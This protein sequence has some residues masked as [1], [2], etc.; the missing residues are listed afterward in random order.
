[1]IRDLGWPGII[2]LGLVQT[3]LGAVVVLTTS[4]LNRIMVVEI[5][6]AA[7]IPGAL[8]A[9]HYAVQL[10]RPRW[11]FGSDAGGRRTPWILGGMAVLA[12]GGFLAA[13]AT[14]L[15]ADRFVPA[16][17]L[18]VLAFLMIGIGVGASGTSL[19][20][21]LAARVAEHRRAA[22]ATTVWVMMIAGF[23][24]TTAVVGSLIDPYSPERLLAASAGV[25]LF[26]VV[27]TALALFRMEPKAATVVPENRAK[28]DF[29]AA[30]AEV[31]AEPQ[32]RRF[33]IFVFVSMLA[34]NG[35]D[36]ILEPFAGLVFGLT[37]GETTKLAGVQH[38]GVLAGMVTMSAVATFFGRAAKRVLTGWMIGG[39]IASA[40]LLATLAATAFAGDVRWLR[41]VV[42]LLGAANGAFAAAAIASMMALAGDGARGREGTRMGLWGA[43]QAIAFGSGGFLGA[44]S[45]D[46]CRSISPDP[47]VAY[48]AVFLGE[49]VLFLLSAILAVRVGRD[50]AA[51]RARAA[52]APAA[53]ASI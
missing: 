32:A 19:L 34:Y 31:W 36:L 33:T 2:R 27:L 12:T 13:V 25:S 40:L 7:A 18:G 50:G 39:C 52:A 9:L 35:Q 42:F 10:L 41:P 30:L 23:I 11:G 45:V 1:M 47:L 15:M 22:A 49:A 4:T 20:A 43:A 3:A 24:A 5:G 26:A 29:R 16:L 37:P 48:S 14:V 44:V 21:L 8:V 6:L 51:A 17:A 46:L 53:T 28:L 38:G